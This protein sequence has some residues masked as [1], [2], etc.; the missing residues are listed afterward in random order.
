MN[1]AFIALGLSFMVQFGGI[2]WFAA[3]MRSG[4]TQL[5]QTTQELHKAV[6]SLS[7]SNSVLDRRLAVLEDRQVSRRDD[8][9]HDRR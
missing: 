3:T 9:I 7:E 4:L 8:P 2:V 1:A 5:N 6:S